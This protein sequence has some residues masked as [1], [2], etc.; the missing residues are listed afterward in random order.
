MRRARPVAAAR[1]SGVGRGCGAAPAG[2]RR[3]RPGRS[4]TGRSAADR[5]LFV[6]DDGWL[7]PDLTARLTTAIAEPGCGFVGSFP[8]GLSYAGDVRPASRWTGSW[9]C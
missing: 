5:V 6:D 4:G 2:R 8:H 1:G 3:T 9:W 7:E